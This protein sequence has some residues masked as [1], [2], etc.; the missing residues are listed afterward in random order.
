MN[1]VKLDKVYV[2]KETEEEEETTKNLEREN[3]K[4]VFHFKWWHKSN[5][6]LEKVNPSMNKI[7][8]IIEPPIFELKL[9]RDHL[10][11]GYLGE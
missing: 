6:P 11:Y 10:K 3:D 4:L 2:E 9:L 8:S 1:E 7:P 5:E